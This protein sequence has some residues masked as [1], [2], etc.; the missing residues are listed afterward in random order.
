M[1]IQQTFKYFI[2]GESNLHRNTVNWLNILSTIVWKLFICILVPLGMTQISHNSPL[3]ANQE[4]SVK[5]LSPTVE[6][7]FAIPNSERLWSS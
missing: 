7:N 5:T 4:K 2:C 3:L 1:L 6:Q